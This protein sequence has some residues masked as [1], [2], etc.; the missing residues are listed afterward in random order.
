MNGA[1][2]SIETILIAGSSGLTHLGGTFARAAHGLGIRA[3]LVDDSL[4]L[5]SS[6]ICNS[7]AWRLHDKRG[8]YSSRVEA[9]VLE[10]VHSTRPQVFLTTGMSPISDSLLGQVSE[11]GVRCIHFSSDDPWSPSR[12]AAWHLR[13]LRKYDVVFSPRT[14]N[15]KDLRQLGCKIVKYAP[16]GF[17][18]TL[19]P[20]QLSPPKSLDGP[21]ILFVGG[22]DPDRATFFREFPLVDRVTFVGGLW[23]R[24]RKF[25]N[26]WAGHRSPHD[27]GPLTKAAAVTIILVRRSN[28]DGHTMRSFE[29]GA[30]GGCLA[31]ERTREHEKIFGADGKC[32]RYFSTPAEAG[33]VCKY[34][35][36]NPSERA[37]LS[38]AVESRIRSGHNTY[39]DRLSSMLLISRPPQIG[40][41]F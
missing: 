15:M 27:I 11:C 3:D 41:L 26:N 39:Q 29:A 16:F 14:S 34:L 30:S 36:E 23:G 17:D 28:R 32:V 33:V 24:Y 8:P 25:K 19:F 40:D 38:A 12:R 13:A 31:V 20:A 6:R 5:S 37:R 2:D 21:A 35:L 18:E 1:V 10:R 9:A 22:A 4:S 7:L